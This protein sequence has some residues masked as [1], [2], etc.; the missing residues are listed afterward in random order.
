MLVFQWGRL[1]HQP[2][3]AAAQGS[4]VKEILERDNKLIRS[5]E[6]P[7]KSLLSCLL[8]IKHMNIYIYIFREIRSFLVFHEPPHPGT[9]A[10]QADMPAAEPADHLSVRFVICPLPGDPLIIV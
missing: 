7:V 2:F 8:A 1:A 6:G 5:G 3:L 9:K 4:V 10:D